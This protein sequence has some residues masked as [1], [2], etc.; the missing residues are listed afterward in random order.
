MSTAI[1]FPGQGSQYVG[2]GLP[3]YEGNERA[4][5]I[6]AKARAAFG[7]ELLDTMFSG[8]EE[9][10]KKTD[11]TQPAIFT[12][13]CAVYEAIRDRVKPAFFAGHSLGEYSA[14]FASGALD[15]ETAFMLVKLRG[16]L[17]QEASAESEGGMAAVLGLDA[18]K[19]KELCAKVSAAGNYLALANINCPGQIV[20]SGDKAG[21]DAGEI[22][23]RELGAKRYIKLAVAGAFHSRLM[24]P[25][26]DAFKAK[27]DSFKFGDATVPVISNVTA[28]AVTSGAEIKKLL[29]EQIVSPVRWIETIE[30]MKAKG[31]DTFIEAGPGA[32]LTGLIKKIDKNLKTINIEKPEDMG[33]L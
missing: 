26:S 33:K 16:S 2:M 25:A 17:M 5:A 14:V 21:I 10:L 22:I 4:N 28:S 12:F 23:A 24:Q 1:I 30:Y 9:I 31:V 11:F 19:V 29:V 13:N 18:E 32:V 6:F 3:F 7:V 27:I 20:V 15:F 8:P